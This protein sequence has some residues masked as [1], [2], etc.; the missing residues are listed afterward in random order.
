MIGSPGPRSV[1]SLGAASGTL[2]FLAATCVALVGGIGLWG[3]GS[4]PFEVS[5]DALVVT[6]VPLQGRG[7]ESAP[8]LFDAIYPHGSRVVYVPNPAEPARVEVLSEGLL[9]AGGPVVGPDGRS[10]LFTGKAS[11]GGDWQVYHTRL[12]GG[13]ARAVSRV[14]GGAV[15]PAWLS[16]TRFVFVAPA[17]A[18]AEAGAEGRRVGVAGFLQ[19]PALHTLALTGGPPVRLTFGLAPA[20]DPTVLA[21]GRILFVSSVPGA[22]GAP[23]AGTSLFTVNNDGTEVTA[24]AGQHEGV[25]TVR[26]PRETDDGRIVFLSGG[27]VRTA[28]PEGRIEQV[29]SARP[30]RSRTVLHPLIAAPCRAAEPDRD[31]RLLATLCESGTD[32]SQASFAVYRLAPGADQPGQPLFDDP[33]WDEV[34][35]MRPA[36]VRPAMG[37]ISSVDPDRPDGVLLCLDTRATDQG[38]GAEVAAAAD[39][40]VG[41]GFRVRVRC[42]KEPGAGAVLGEA[43]IHPDGSFLVRVPADV[44]LGL[45]LLDAQG[46]LVRRCPPGFWVR[47]GENRACVG[48]HEPH[49]HAP[50]NGRPLAVRLPA[51]DL[52]AA[53]TAGDSHGPNGGTRR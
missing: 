28:A 46:G 34:E 36:R 30:F 1:A 49:N 18:R 7:G 27:G 4:R 26:R 35:A 31:G 10:V 23:G 32:R 50:E 29:L 48:C 8:D 12:G 2:G 37:R 33:R 21:D 22:S 45:D 39:A 41:S 20:T 43:P 25:A 52:L 47:P 6:Q 38:G 3:C 17:P 40:P 51:V 15:T 42:W 44:P 13:T 5:G 14:A 11:P 9:A 19:V 24:Y 53:R 16:S